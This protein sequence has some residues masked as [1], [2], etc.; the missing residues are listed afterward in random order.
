MVHPASG[1]LKGA[2]FIGVLWSLTQAWGVRVITLV[3]FVVIARLLEPADLGVIAFAA[4]IVACLSTLVDQGMTTIVESTVDHDAKMLDSAWWATLAASVLVCA[5]IVFATPALVQ[6]TGKS[7]LASLLPVLSLTVVLSATSAIQLALLKARFLNRSIALAHL[8]GSVVGATTGIVCALAG[9]AYW[10]L[11]AKAL[12]EGA[13]ISALLVWLSPWKPRCRF[14][15]AAWRGLLRQSRPVIGMRLLDIVNL[16]LDA[17]LIGSRLGASALGF[18]ST[19][20][21]IYQIL[22]EVLFSAVNQVSLPIFSRFNGQPGRAADI[23]LRL[24]SCTSLLTFPVFALM[25]ATAVDLITVVFGEKWRAAGPV[26]AVFALGG[27]LFSVSYFNAPVLLASGRARQLFWLS[28]LNAVGNTVGYLIAVPFGATAVAAAYVIRGF[29]VYPVNLYFL[30]QACGVSVTRYARTLWPAAAASGLA[31]AAALACGAEL[32]HWPAAGR[33][34][35]AWGAG[36][37][38]YVLVIASVFRTE[39]FSAVAEVRAMVTAARAP[40][41]SMNLEP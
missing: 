12:V 20:Q 33:L 39:A 40:G 13:L 25:S 22:M 15:A 10:S 29:V 7:Y 19:G 32:A 38:V 30:R 24:V 1:G 18:Y 41:S 28:L 4:T 35:A 11:V 9:L 34:L 16:R 26:L 21:R 23:L 36:V 17:L 3:H 2:A 37:G 5:G 31:A 6:W 8:I 14:D 27:V